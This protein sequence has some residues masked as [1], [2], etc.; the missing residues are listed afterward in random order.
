MTTEPLAADQQERRAIV[1][2][3]ILAAF[4]DGTQSQD[5]RARIQQI[6]NGCSGESSDVT[7]VYQ[8]VLGG[9]LPAR[10]GRTPGSYWLFPNAL[11]LFEC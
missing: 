8:D 1:G 7:T 5:E 3:C 9:K 2:I 6:V 10:F 11:A 4:A